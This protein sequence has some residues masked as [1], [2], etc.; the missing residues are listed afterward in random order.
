M[1]YGLIGKNITYSYSDKIHMMLSG[2]SYELLSLSDEQKV[3]DFLKTD[4][5][6]INIT[7]P[8]KNLAYKSVDSLS[9]IARK[10]EV[11]NTVIKKD[12]KLYG[13]NTDVYGFSYLLD[14]NSIEI[15]DKNCLILGTGATSRTVKFVLENKGAKSIKFLSRKPDNKTSFTYG[16]KDIIEQAEIIVNTTPVGT[17]ENNDSLLDFGDCKSLEYYVDVVYNPHKTKMVIEARD[18]GIK[19]VGGLDMLIAQAAKS[20]ELFIGR[21]HSEDKYHEIRVFLEKSTLQ[22]VFIGHPFAGKTA[23]SR[24]FNKYFK[25]N[26]I[27]VDEEIIR[28]EN[29]KTIPE[30]FEE[31][32]EAYFRS[33]E[34]QIIKELSCKVGYLIS[35]GGGAVLNNENMDLLRQNSIIFNVKRDIEKISENDIKNRPLCKDKNELKNII[36]NRKEIYEKYAD[37]EVD[38][39]GLL[40]DSMKRIWRCL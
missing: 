5:K 32:G 23:L 8:Y 10:T 30:I 14:K 2:N 35:L 9:E 29:G 38:N 26:F 31:K 22:I 28:R 18:H 39:S 27:D 40:E 37:F 21:E 17:S 25:G 3:L 19:S 36:K 16:Q 6:G 34:T 12:G 20:N 7:I 11:V 15:K 1:E 33:L 4:F 24:E 13:Y